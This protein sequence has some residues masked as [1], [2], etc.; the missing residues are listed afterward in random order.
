MSFLGIDLGTSFIKGA[1]LNLEKQQLEH[2]RRIPFPD[3][4]ATDDPLR[5][6]FDPQAI[7]VAF[8]TLMNELVPFAFD[9]EGVVMCT[10]MHGLVLMDERHR[11]VSN[12]ITWRDQRALSLHPSGAGTYFDTIL[13]QT[14]ESERQ[15]LGNELEP[16][17]PLC[18]LFWLKEQGQLI[19]GLVPASLPDF[20]ISTLSG[21]DPGVDPTNASSYGAFNLETS[22]WHFDVIRRLGLE[23]LR[24]PGVRKQTD[25]A[26]YLKV[27]SRSVPCYAPVGDAQ[28]ALAGS[29]LK[30]EELSLNIAT[31]AQV[32]RVID[33]LKLGSYQTRPYFDGQFL[34]TF[35]YPPAGRALNVL[36]GLVSEF[37]AVHAVPPQ[38]PW[39]YIAEKTAEVRVTDLDLD[40][41]FFPGPEGNAGH[42][43]N[44][45]ASNLSVGHLFRAAFRSMAESYF[46][47]AVKLW[48]E[49]AWKN[50]VLSGGLACKMEALQQEIA[51]RFE[52][53]FRLSPQAEDTLFGLLI[54]ATVCSG[55]A[56]SLSDVRL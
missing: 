30:A 35:S 45:N 23:S 20:V 4:V 31:G 9:C 28:A 53:S 40:L 56:K 32:S 46:Q 37:A 5:C 50:L 36:V 14:S 51:Q 39:A 27:G 52:T 21:D 26:G 1:V 2:V 41:N 6:E 49:R 34:D 43:C 16:S 18:F 38:D 54:L 7:L 12:C 15:Q 11:A 48:P 10:Q 8:Q 13:A 29:L 55:R 24:W 33:E 25:V 42:I 3:P 44:I 17:R 22:D 19:P 47:C